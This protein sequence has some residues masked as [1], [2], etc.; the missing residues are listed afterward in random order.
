MSADVEVASV[1]QAEDGADEF[2]GNSHTINTDD[3]LPIDPHSSVE[4]RQFTLRAVLVG[5]ALGAVITSD[6]YLR[7]TVRLSNS[8][9]DVPRLDVANSIRPGGPL[10]HP[11]LASSLASPLSNP[12]RR[13]ISAAAT[14]TPKKKTCKPLRAPP[15]RSDCSSPPPLPIRSPQRHPSQDIGY[16]F[17]FTICCAFFGLAFSITLRRFFI[18]IATFVYP[19]GV[20]AA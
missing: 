18:L 2:T 20:A 16:L 1:D 7:L 8:I 17:I 3:P 4:E 11:P 10:V 15:T 5:C 19:P 6:V 14:F 12:S 13:A 9:F